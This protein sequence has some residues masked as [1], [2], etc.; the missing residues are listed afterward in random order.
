MRHDKHGDQQNT[1][2]LFC[3]ITK[4]HSAASNWFDSSELLQSQGERVKRKVTRQPA[5][6]KFPQS[7]TPRSRPGRPLQE[8]GGRSDRGVTRALILS[9]PL[10]P[11][12]S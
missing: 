8:T 11:T 5:E 4:L 1:T 7:V 10:T 2:H 6:E 9:D 12:V 3:K